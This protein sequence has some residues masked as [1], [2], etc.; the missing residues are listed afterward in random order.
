M[1]EPQESSIRKNMLSKQ[2]NSAAE[3]MSEGK[4]LP[5]EM[6]AAAE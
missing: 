3:L 5:E 1:V 4:R 6:I 2:Q